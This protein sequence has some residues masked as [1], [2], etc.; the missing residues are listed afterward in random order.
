MGHLFE[1]LDPDLISDH[2]SDVISKM[3]EEV[4][5]KLKSSLGH[6]LPETCC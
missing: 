3:L 5:L 2:T 1:G 6:R 4:C